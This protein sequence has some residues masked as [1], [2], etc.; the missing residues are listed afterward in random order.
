MAH[1]YY[2]GFPAKAA[3]AAVDNSIYLPVEILKHLTGIFGAFFTRRIRRGRGKRKAAVTQQLKGK[4]MI[5]AAQADCRAACQNDGRYLGL[6]L[7]HDGQRSGPEAG[8]K[9]ARLL[10]NIETQGVHGFAAV[11]HERQRLYGRAALD[12]IYHAHC[13]L[14]QSAAGKAVHRLRRD[15]DKTAVSDYFCGTFRGT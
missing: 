12:L 7:Q 13:L 3:S 9:C 6:G 15:G 2:R 11:D 14:V 4:R 10:G 1:V 8:G 5:R